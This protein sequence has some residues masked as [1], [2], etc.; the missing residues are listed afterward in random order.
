MKLALKKPTAAAAAEGE[1][2]E[3][4]VPFLGSDGKGRGG[5]ETMSVLGRLAWDVEPVGTCART[6]ATGD[7]LR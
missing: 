7:P 5:T 2:K 6:G 4:Q 1:E 3:T